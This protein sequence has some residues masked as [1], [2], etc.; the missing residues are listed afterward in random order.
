MKTVNELKKIVQ[1]ALKEA[2]DCRH[3]HE[4]SKRSKTKNF[5]L[6][7]CK[8]LELVEM[9]PSVDY[10][11]RARETNDKRLAGIKETAQDLYRNKEHLH[12]YNELI[13]DFVSKN[14]GSDLREQNRYIDY[15]LQDI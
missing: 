7:V 6:F 9:N 4:K 13:T 2:N 3:D 15:I 14:G 12:N 11:Q 1:D 8:C 5:Y 10:L